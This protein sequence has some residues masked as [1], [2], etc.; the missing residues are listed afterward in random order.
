MRIFPA[1]L[2]ISTLSVFGAAN[3]QGSHPDQPMPVAEFNQQVVQAHRERQL[4]VI[5]SKVVAYKFVGAECDCKTRT[6]EIE[7]LAP[8][9]DAVVRYTITDDGL[10]DDS[11]QAVR[12][13]LTLRETRDRYWLIES[14]GKSWACAPNR[15]HI[16]F[17][18]ELC[19]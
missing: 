14:A 4:W 15:G 5:A 9:P 10:Q 12:Y 13:T 11:V 2:T 3:S 1:L 8:E 18:A 16:Y 17:S 19:S 6:V 7:R